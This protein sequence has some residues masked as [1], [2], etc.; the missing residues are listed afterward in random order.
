MFQDVVFSVN[1]TRNGYDSWHVVSEDERTGMYT[2][3]DPY[4]AHAKTGYAVVYKSRQELFALVNFKRVPLDPWTPASAFDVLETRP[5]TRRGHASIVPRS[6]YPQEIRETDHRKATANTEFAKLVASHGGDDDSHVVYLDTRAACTTFAL[7]REGVSWSRLVCPQVDKEEYEV[8]HA[9]MG[10]DVVQYDTLGNTLRRFRDDGQDVGALFADY[11]CTW[12]GNSEICPR[13]DMKI[14]KT[15]VQN[16]L[17][18]TLS[19]RGVKVDYSQIQETFGTEWSVV[20]QLEYAS[21][22]TIG[23]VR[24]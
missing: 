11:C 5:S 13:Q 23:F 7:L 17:F 20:F 9:K 14:A 21:V 22:V 2:L 3:R 16:V 24:R 10:G 1:T 4:T 6:T 15:L 12:E 8:M 19:R 18:I